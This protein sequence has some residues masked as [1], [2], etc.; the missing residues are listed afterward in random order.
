MN[1]LTSV[2]SLCRHSPIFWVDMQP[3]MHTFTCPQNILCWGLGSPNCDDGC[4]VGGEGL[5]P[6][7]GH[8]I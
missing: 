5:F 4:C 1:M 8:Y 6:R 7:P 3:S 2:G